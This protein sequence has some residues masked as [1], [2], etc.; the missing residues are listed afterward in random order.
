MA[1]AVAWEAHILGCPNCGEGLLVRSPIRK[2]DTVKCPS[3]G[4]NMTVESVCASCRDDKGRV[5]H[6]AVWI[7][8]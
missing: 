4:K 6:D 5:K 3:C 8:A 1:K 7:D 2:G